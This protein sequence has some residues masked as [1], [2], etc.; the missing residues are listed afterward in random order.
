MVMSDGENVRAR[1]MST[2]E[3]LRALDKLAE[4]MPSPRR[5]N[6]W[7]PSKLAEAVVR[8]VPQPLDKLARKAVRPRISRGIADLFRPMHAASRLAGPPMLVYFPLWHVKGSHECFYLRDASYKIRVD[9]DVV[10][11]E[12]DGDTRDLMME[13]Q[14]S[15]IVPEAFGRTLMRFSRLFTGERRYFCLNDA[16]ELAVRYEQAEMCVTSDGREANVLEEILPSNWKRQRV[17]DTAQLNVEGANTSIAASAD[18]KEIVVEK[19]QRRLVKMPET[20][21]Q[22]L[23][24]TFQ[25]EELTEYY[26]PYA[27]FPVMRSG[28]VESVIIN[29]ASAQIPDEKTVNSVK[30][31][32]GLGA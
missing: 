3:R 30:R 26:V 15:K 13:E 10:A 5:G 16:V 1:I 21:K 20:S 27:C 9:K 6:G 2:L 24:N 14:E 11:V 22:I 23:S 19:F 8:V 18:T 25:I 7:D 17:F 4:E 32:L 12:V 31:Q 29:A 28:R